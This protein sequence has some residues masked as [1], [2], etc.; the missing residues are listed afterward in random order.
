MTTLKTALAL[1]LAA[2]LPAPAA[3]AQDHAQGHAKR[4]HPDRA[5]AQ[6]P[7]APMTLAQFQALRVKRFMRMDADRDGRVSRAEFDAATQREHAEDA[8]AGAASPHAGGHRRH[9]MF[10]RLDANHDGYVTAAE[11]QA[12]AAARFAAIDVGHKGVITLNQMMAARE[13]RRGGGE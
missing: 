2:L 5:A 7:D 8:A 4:D 1:A 3:H 11:V 10:G 9:D 6:N 13:E 12:A